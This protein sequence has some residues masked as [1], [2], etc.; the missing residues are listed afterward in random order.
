[1]RHEIIAKYA[2]LIGL[3][4][5]EAWFLWNPNGWIFEWEPIVC[6]VGLLG[7]YI[8]LDIKCREKDEKETA[9]IHSVGVSEPKGFDSDNSE[10]KTVITMPPQGSQANGKALKLLEPAQ[11]KDIK[12]KPANL[13]LE[14]YFRRIKT[15]ED[16]FLEKAEFVESIKGTQVSWKAIVDSVGRSHSGTVTISLSS[17]S[18]DLFAIVCAHLPQE[19]ET[20]AFSLRKGDKVIVEGILKLDAINM[21]D[22]EATS[23]KV[24]TT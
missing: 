15:L 2:A 9:S 13:S 24:V 5:T 4:A 8:S 19:F 3:L 12:L 14:E 6:F 16:R 21:P 18:K 22:I 17:L 23:L 20:K 7:A 1:M 10:Q 11:E